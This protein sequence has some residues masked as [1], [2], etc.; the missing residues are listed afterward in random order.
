MLAP[1]AAAQSDRSQCL[2][3]QLYSRCD[4]IRVNFGGILM[5]TELLLAITK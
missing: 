5:R 3:I 4:S 2:R 1:P